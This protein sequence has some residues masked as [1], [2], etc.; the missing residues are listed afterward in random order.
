MS[1]SKTLGCALLVTGTSIGAGML[2]IPLVVAELGF[3]NTIALLFVIWFF[4]YIAS[5]LILDITIAV[6]PNEQTHLNRMAK[7]VLGKTGQFAMWICVIGLLY[8]LTIAYISGGSSILAALFEHQN[9]HLPQWVYAALFTLILGGVVTFSTRATDMVNRSL[10]VFKGIL[11][12]VMLAFSLPHIDMHILFETATNQKYFLVAAP[13]I[14]VSFGFHHIVPTLAQ[15]TDFNI[16]LLKRILLI[17]SLIPFVIYLLWVVM[18]LGIM[19]RE[20][21]TQDVGEFIYS[22]SEALQRPSMLWI[23]NGFANFAVITSF[24]GVTLGL[25]DFLRDNFKVAADDMP[26]RLGISLLAFAVPFVFAITIPAGFIQLL[27]YGGVFFA[28]MAYV[29]PPIMA[30]KLRLGTVM[31]ALVAVFGVAIAVIGVIYV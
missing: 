22:L 4:S 21:L 25:F 19:P 6:S 3:I 30:F 26:K 27:A 13:V 7:E 23:V 8:S 29:L 12:V 5:L 2:G 11:L 17:G 10:F 1:L 14:F 16:K 9:I 18:A 15:Y 20:M 24:L 31:P 28:L